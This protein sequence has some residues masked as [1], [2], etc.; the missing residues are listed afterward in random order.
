MAAQEKAI[1]S[2]VKR[3]GWELVEVI[4]D[5]GA[6]GKSLDRP[7]LRR[8]LDQIA[9]GEV[10]GL[11][12]AKLD[13]ITRS[14]G[15][16]AALLEWFTASDASLVAVDVG[17]DTSSPGGKLVAGVFAAVA[18]WERDTIAA[19]TK[20]GLAALRAKGNAISRPAV[21][22]NPRL[23]R[24]IKGMRERGKTYQAIAD[25]LNAERVPTL[26]GARLWTV[27][28]VRGAAGYR[29]PPARRKVQELPPLKRRRR[30]AS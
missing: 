28:G 1:R 22:D 19:R 29:P 23:A 27:S 3:R 2:E 20:E 18:E 21:A 26:R 7:G 14:L 25:K 4:R 30:R 13:R 15:D 12:A 24:R 10:E 5:E 6:S 17:V 9:A 11:V 8:A 16:F